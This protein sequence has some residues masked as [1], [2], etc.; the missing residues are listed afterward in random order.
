MSLLPRA[1]ISVTVWDYYIEKA[2]GGGG[3]TSITVE[4]LAYMYFKLLYSP[5]FYQEAN[6]LIFHPIVSVVPIYKG[7]GE[8]TG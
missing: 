2:Q 6:E 5:I 7:M 3:C 8:M 4:K 1:V